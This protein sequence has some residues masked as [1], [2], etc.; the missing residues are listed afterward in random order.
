MTQL[1]V[2]EGSLW[3]VLYDTANAPALNSQVYIYHAYDPQDL[4]D[5]FTRNFTLRLVAQRNRDL[6]EG[7]FVRMDIWARI[8]QLG[9]NSITYGTSTSNYIV[10]APWADTEFVR[11]AGFTSPE[12]GPLDQTIEVSTNYPMPTTDP[13]LYMLAIAVWN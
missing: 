11:H 8:G 4:H 2:R 5:E 7:A 1:K 10:T 13:S 3:N 6:L 9:S 12:P